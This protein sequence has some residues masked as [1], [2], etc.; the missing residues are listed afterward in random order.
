MKITPLGDPK[1][2]A[3]FLKKELANSRGEF[4]KFYTDITRKL[5]DSADS[6]EV[7]DMYQRL[8][9]LYK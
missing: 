3:N 7:K 4:R 8:I 5:R 1:D 2:I 9:D 6:E